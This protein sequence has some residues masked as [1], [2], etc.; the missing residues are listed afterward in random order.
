MLKVLPPWR[1]STKAVT[2]MPRNAASRF[3]PAGPV[4]VGIAENPRL[5]S[6]TG[7]PLA[8]M[9]TAPWGWPWQM[10]STINPPIV[11]VEMPQRRKLVPRMTPTG[12]PTSA[13]L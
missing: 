1:C 5:G 10:S 2:R 7:N 9:Y 13:K 4:R 8:A 6:V 3:R 12:W 11:P